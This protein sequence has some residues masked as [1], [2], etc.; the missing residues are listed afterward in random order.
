MGQLGQVIFDRERCRVK[1]GK[2]WIPTHTA[3]SRSTPLARAI[4]AQQEEEIAVAASR[5][6]TLIIS[7]GLSMEQ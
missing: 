3:L 2:S 7:D 1:L 5:S 4:I 6:A